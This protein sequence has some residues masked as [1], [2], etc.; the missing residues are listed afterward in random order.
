MRAAR[1]NWVRVVI[2]PHETLCEC[3]QDDFV[4]YLLVVFTTAEDRI[5]LAEHFTT[6]RFMLHCVSIIH[7]FSWSHL[8]FSTVEE[9]KA[10]YTF[11]GEFYQAFKKSRIISS[12]KMNGSSSLRQLSSEHSFIKLIPHNQRCFYFSPQE[13]FWSNIPPRFERSLA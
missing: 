7:P 10:E 8:P 9:R 12:W 4:L 13:Y 5:I 6:L 1:K 2:Y 3:A 11:D